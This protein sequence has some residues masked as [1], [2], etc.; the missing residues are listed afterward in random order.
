MDP[1]GCSTVGSGNLADDHLVACEQ[2]LKAID[3]RMLFVEAAMNAPRRPAFPQW[4]IDLVRDALTFIEGEMGG[5]VTAATIAKR[6]PS[7]SM[8]EMKYLE[9]QRRLARN[10]K[11]THTQRQVGS[12]MIP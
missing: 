7:L 2:R 12:I 6:I 9:A 4:K 8:A 5:P 11:H 3:A 1:A 10:P